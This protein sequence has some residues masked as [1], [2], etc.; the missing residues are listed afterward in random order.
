LS[1]TSVTGE[2]QSAA[3]FDVAEAKYDLVLS[4]QL[5]V[6][7]LPNKLL[8]SMLTHDRHHFAR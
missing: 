7:A 6:G 5:V 3:Y 1:D 8:A 2:K 4:P